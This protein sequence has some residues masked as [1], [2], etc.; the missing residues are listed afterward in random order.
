MIKISCIILNYNTAEMTKKAIKHFLAA[1]DGT[2]AELI[3][4]DNGSTEPFEY[5]GDSRSRLIRNKTNKGFAAAVNQALSHCQGQYVLLLNSDVLIDSDALHG[6]VDFAETHPELGAIG[7]L[8]KFPDGFFQS[9]CGF[10]PS[11]WSEFLR[12]STLGKYLPGGTLFYKNIFTRKTFSKALEVDWLSGGCLLLRG[13][14]MKQVGNLD[15]RYFFGVE[16]F[17]YCYRLKAKGWKVIYLPTVSVIH[18]HSFSAGGHGSA[19]SL[20]LERAGMNYFWRRHFPKRRLA[21]VLVDRMYGAKLWY[22][23][24]LRLDS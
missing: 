7:P 19:Y 23:E 18:Y 14:A 21:R 1:L 3:V 24:K 22:L 13:E 9:S 17:D 20:R 8:M 6:L 12:F 5:A 4:I 2:A 15:E 10:M 11:L 16:D